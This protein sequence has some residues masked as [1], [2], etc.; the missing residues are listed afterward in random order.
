MEQVYLDSIRPCVK[1]RRHSTV[2]CNQS[3]ADMIISVR[4]ADIVQGAACMLWDDRGMQCNSHSGLIVKAQY[5][6]AQN[7][8]AWSQTYRLFLSLPSKGRN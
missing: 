4:V 1:T 2:A 8:P 5:R 7:R 6:L 3:V